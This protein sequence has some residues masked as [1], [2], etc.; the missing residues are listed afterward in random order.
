[1]NFFLGGGGYQIGPKLRVLP[2]SQ[3]H[4][5]SFPWHC[6]RLQRWTISNICFFRLKEFPIGSGK[7]LVTKYQGTLSAVSSKCTHYGAPLITGAYKDGKIR[8]PW[9]GA[10]FSAVTGDIED[11]PG[12]DSL[13]SYDVSKKYWKVSWGYFIVFW[14]T[15]S[16][17]EKE[18]AYNSNNTI[19][20]GYPSLQFIPSA[21]PQA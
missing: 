12:L 9:H 15:L 7:V 18:M 14:T 1:M 6:T 4:I 2:I 3:G 13:Q 19:F 11:Y 10:C 5:I 20:V 21:A 8:C 17:F 16:V